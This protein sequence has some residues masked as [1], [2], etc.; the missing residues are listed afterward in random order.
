MQ[1]LE[2][3]VQLLENSRTIKSIP[4]INSSI[5]GVFVNIISH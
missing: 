1:F 2:K 4:S 5:T 3:M